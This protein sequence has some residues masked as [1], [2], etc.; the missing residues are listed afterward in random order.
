VRG[1]TGEGAPLQR[2]TIID[3][4]VESYQKTGI[5]VAGAVDASITLNR[6]TGLGPVDHIAQN[7]IQLSAGAR[8]TVQWNRVEQNIYTGSGAAST[9]ILLLGAGPGIEI[10]INRIEDNDIG[11]RVISTSDAVMQWND[12][13]GSTYDGIAIDGL[14]A[15]A[16]GNQV[17]R[18]RLGDNSIGIDIFGASAVSNEVIGNRISDSLQAGI[19]VAFGTTGNVLEENRLQ[20]NVSGA[21]VSADANDIIGNVIQNSDSV[22]LHVDGDGNDVQ[23]NTVSGSGSLDVANAGA[24]TYGGNSCSTSTGAPVDCP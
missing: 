5:F 21:F 18:N 2:V 4:R 23:G 10:Q 16:Q 15:A 6:I 3:N 22:G 17:V 12:V 14:Q 1:A 13:S 8:G 19:Q 20:R 24:N 9:G 7:G 11:V